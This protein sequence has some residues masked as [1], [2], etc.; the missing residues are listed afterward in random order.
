MT[1]PELQISFIFIFYLQASGLLYFT[2]LHWLLTLLNFLGSPGDPGAS[3]AS[4]S[5]G[6]EEAVLLR[7]LFSHSYSWKSIKTVFLITVLDA[8]MCLSIFYVWFHLC[9]RRL[10]MNST[11][12]IAGKFSP[13]EV[14][15]KEG[16]RIPGSHLKDDYLTMVLLGSGGLDEL[17]LCDLHVQIKID[18]PFAFFIC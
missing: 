8:A 3:P 2:E 12:L 15:C 10:C 7:H 9:N 14:I 4:G 17:P 5:L 16:N 18:L 13:G 6:N 11:L 1:A